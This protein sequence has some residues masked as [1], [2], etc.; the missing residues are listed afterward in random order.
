MHRLRLMLISHV[1]KFARRSNVSSDLKIFRKIS[2]VR[3]S[4]SSCLPTNLYATLNTFRQ[5]WRT[6]ASHAC[7]SPRKQRWMSASTASGG[8]ADESGDIT[9]WVEYRT[10]LAIPTVPSGFF[11]QAHDL[12]CDG[13]PLERIAAAAGTPVY[14]YSAAAIR[15]RYRA[16]DDAF[17]G[18]PHSLHYALKANSSVAVA[19]LLREAGSAVDANSIWEIEL[20]R[21]AGFAPHEIVFTGVGKSAAELECAVT[22]GL[23]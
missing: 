5:Y 18:Y 7:W 20:A 8:A 2:C 11:R 1:W 13:V 14:V 6:I 21:K 12:V 16:I 23:K 4:A 3:S 10:T 9:D 15:E 17:G 19:R 22:L